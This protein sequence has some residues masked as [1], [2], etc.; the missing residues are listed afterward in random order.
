MNKDIMIALGFG[1]QVDLVNQSKCPF[2][3]TLVDPSKFKDELSFKEYKI[4]GL[5]QSCQNEM[6]V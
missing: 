5:C 4:S 6:F 1:K 3:A 2:C